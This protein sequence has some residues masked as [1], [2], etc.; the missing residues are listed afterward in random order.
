MELG[1]RVIR[2]RII[3]LTNIGVSVG[4]SPV[5]GGTLVASQLGGGSTTS[6]EL[7][8]VA[9]RRGLSQVSMLMTKQVEY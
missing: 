3:S 8:E 4:L 5:Y 7:E 2:A 1:S 9:G 6:R